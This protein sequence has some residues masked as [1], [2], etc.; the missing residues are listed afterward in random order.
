MNSKLYGYVSGGGL[1]SIT[2]SVITQFAEFCAIPHGSRNEKEIMEYLCRLLRDQGLAPETDSVGNLICDIPASKG[3][4]ESPLT[5]LQGHVDMVCAVKD[6]SYSPEKDPILWQ[7]GEDEKTGRLVLCT[8]GRSSLGADCG[9][10]NA[11]LLWVLSESGCSHGPLRLILTVEE[12]TGLD[13]AKKMDASPFDDVKYVINVDGFS[14]G[15]FIGGSAGGCRETYRAEAEIIPFSE[16]PISAEKCRA[17]EVCLLEFHGGHSG[18]DINKGR[19]NPIK[20]LNRLLIELEQADIPYSISAYHGGVGNN[21]IPADAAAAIVLK[22]SDLLR[23]QQVVKPFMNRLVEEFEFTD[24]EG[25]MCYNEI[26]LPHSV[27]TEEWKRRVIE[28]IEDIKNGVICYMEDIPEVVDTSSNLGMIQFPA[29]GSNAGRI[30][31]TDKKNP[32]ASAPVRTAE[33]Y[34]KSFSRSMTA[35]HRDELLRDHSDAAKR[36]GFEEDT[37]GYGIWH[38]DRNNPLLRLAADVY[39]GMTGEEPEVT[40][41]HVGLEP[42]AFCE[43]A[44]GLQMINVGPDIIDAHSVHERANVDTIRPFAL[45]MAE[46]LEQIA[47]RG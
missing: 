37:E 42:S 4:E 19:A 30:R 2:S 31:E 33:F 43:K 20:L 10:G 47:E 6:D 34:V 27:L 17:F 28:F 24:P 44:E 29:S 13:G 39:R 21:V 22:N 23:F 32:D 41:V 9:L 1:D 5:V 35:S 3:F 18:Y 40:A 14:W 25:L 11:V 8:D 26:S 36:Y 38:F 45:F 16:D 46:L 15:R 7:L 12:E